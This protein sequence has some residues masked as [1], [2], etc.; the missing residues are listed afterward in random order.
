MSMLSLTTPTA[1]NPMPQFFFDIL[2]DGEDVTRDHKGVDLPD[3]VAA[4]IEALEVWKRIVSARA[5]GGADCQHW[6][7]AILDV[8]GQRLEEV[9]YPSDAESG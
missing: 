4:K 8:R 3:L 6:R 7:V 2:H 5:A 1:G 9:P